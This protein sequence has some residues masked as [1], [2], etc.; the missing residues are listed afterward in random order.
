MITEKPHQGNERRTL[1]KKRVLLDNNKGHGW[2]PERR[3]RSRKRTPGQRSLSLPVK[4]SRG[5]SVTWLRYSVSIAGWLLGRS[6]FQHRIAGLRRELG[7][8]RRHFVSSSEVSVFSWRPFREGPAWYMKSARE[9]TCWHHETRRV[10]EVTEVSEKF[11]TLIQYSQYR[12]LQDEHL[13]LLVLLAADRTSHQTGSARATARSYT[14]DRGS[15][16]AP[17][18]SKRP[19]ATKA[20]RERCA[21]L[22]DATRKNFKRNAQSRALFLLILHFLH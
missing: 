7:Y 6:Y 17:H 11:R 15:W 20:R 22:R 8:T 19:A 2:R 10:T 1:W 14:R 16:A 4:A 12:P 18:A 21:A 9:S 3:E 5:A 13:A